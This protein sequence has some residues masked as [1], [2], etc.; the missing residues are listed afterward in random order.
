MIIC[1]YAVTASA[2]A[3]AAAA[4]VLNF[5]HSIQ[6]VSFSLLSAS[7]TRTLDRVS[8]AR[9]RLLLDRTYCN[10][11][12]VELSSFVHNCAFWP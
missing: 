11:R 2:A 1:C 10:F 7:H 6:S 8:A 5:L 4:A 9:R 12:S 3:A